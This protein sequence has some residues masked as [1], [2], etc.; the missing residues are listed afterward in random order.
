[1]ST[2]LTMRASWD[3]APRPP[4]HLKITGAAPA[5]GFERCEDVSCTVEADGTASSCG[6]LACPSCGCGGTNLTTVAL[7]DAGSATSIG[8]SCGYSWVRTELRSP[9]LSLTG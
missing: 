6:R 7:L 8:C 9:A 2:S 5:Y 3:A 4:R 1:M